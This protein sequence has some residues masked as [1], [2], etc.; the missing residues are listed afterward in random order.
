MA[1]GGADR[2]IS[3]KNRLVAEGGGGG[4]GGVDLG[5]MYRR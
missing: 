4:G 1:G 5:E 3:D 2:K